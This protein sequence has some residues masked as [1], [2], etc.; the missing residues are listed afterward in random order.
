MVFRDF[1]R[2]RI[3]SSASSFSGDG[4]V[5]KIRNVGVGGL[6]RGGG[7]DLDSINASDMG[8]CDVDLL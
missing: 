4:P 2:A 3:N 5:L 8:G 7:Y 6:R 1:K